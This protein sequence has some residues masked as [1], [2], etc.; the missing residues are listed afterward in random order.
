MILGLIEA[1][2]AEKEEE[3]TVASLANPLRD[4]L[5]ILARDPSGA[6]DALQQKLEEPFWVRRTV[7]VQDLRDAL[8]ASITNQ[9]AQVGRAE[10]RQGLIYLRRY[11]GQSRQE[12]LES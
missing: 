3:E 6:G 8:I 7:A 5:A 2:R 10:A 9:D 4:I 12:G 1:L 11:V